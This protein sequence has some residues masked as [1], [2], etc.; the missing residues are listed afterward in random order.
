MFDATWNNGHLIPELPV[1][2]SP[3]S[4]RADPAML[5]MEEGH[6]RCDATI[7]QVPN[8]V[9]IECAEPSATFSA[10]DNPVQL[11]NPKAWQR[12]QQGLGAHESDSGW[13][14]R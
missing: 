12:S 14:G 4:L 9:E 1:K 11:L 6:G 7:S 13:S 8:P 10:R 3:I 2:H 5:F